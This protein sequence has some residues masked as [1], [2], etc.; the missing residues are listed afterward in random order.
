[1]LR[2]LGADAIVY[3]LYDRWSLRRKRLAAWRAEVF[4]WARWDPEILR[5]TGQPRDGTD[6]TGWIWW[7][8]CLNYGWIMLNYG[9]VVAGEMFGLKQ[10]WKVQTSHLY[11]VSCM[12]CES[13]FFF[14][15]KHVGTGLSRAVAVSEF[16]Q[17]QSAKAAADATSIRRNSSRR[18]ILGAP[19]YIQIP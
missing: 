10:S 5:S 16:H 9:W 6:G 12:S 4:Q 13:C 18:P 3:L 17:G 2:S 1:M 14:R 19:K 11:H 7:K 15:L 8:K